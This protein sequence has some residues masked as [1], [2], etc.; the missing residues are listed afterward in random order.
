MLKFIEVDMTPIPKAREKNGTQV[1]GEE[2]DVKLQ[3]N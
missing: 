1:I 3:E 2:K